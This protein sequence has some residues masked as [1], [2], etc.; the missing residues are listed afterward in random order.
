MA[1]T[2]QDRAADKIRGEAYRLG[3][4]TDFENAAAIEAELIRMGLVGVSEALDGLH[5]RLDALCRAPRR[6]GEPGILGM[7]LDP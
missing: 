1:R 6:G 2:S 4:S 3:F 7:F 5:A